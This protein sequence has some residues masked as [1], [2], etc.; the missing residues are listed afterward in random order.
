M[1]LFLLSIL[2]LSFTISANAFTF[3]F[4]SAPTQCANTTAVWTGGQAPFTL[5]LVPVGHLS[6]ETRTIIQKDVPSGNSVSFVLNFPAQSQFVAIL[7]DATG[8]GAGGTSSII[9]VGSSSDSSC[10]STTPSQAKF[11][12]FLPQD[13]GQCDS[14]DISWGSQAQDPVDILGVIPAG[15][16]FEIANVTDSSTSLQWTADV[17]SGTQ[18]MFVAGD[19]DG[20]GTGGSSDV[21]KVSNG[22]SDSCIN[23]NSPSSTSGAAAGGV[24]STAQG[25]PAGGTT[26]RGTLVVTTDNVGSTVTVGGTVTTDGSGSTTTIIGSTGPITTT[27][28]AGSTVTIAGPGGPITTTDNAGSTVTIGPTS[29]IT[30]DNSGSTITLGGGGSTGVN[31]PGSQSSGFTGSG[32]GTVTGS[33]KNGLDNRNNRLGLILGLVLGLLALGLVVAGIILYRRRRQERMYRNLETGANGA[34]RPHPWVSALT[35][36]AHIRGG[37]GS[38]VD[39]LPSMYQT[40]PFIMPST[41]DDSFSV[42]QPRQPPPVQQQRP[43]LA[44]RASSSRSMYSLIGDGLFTRDV[45]GG[46]LAGIHGPDRKESV[47]PHG[48][49]PSRTPSGRAVTQ[50]TVLIPSTIEVPT[51]VTRDSE[52]FSPEPEGMSPNPFNDDVVEIPPTYASVRRASRSG[53]RETW[54]PVRAQLRRSNA[55]RHSRRS[56]LSNSGTGS[57][58]TS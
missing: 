3:S 38:S 55:S 2:L 28:N 9:T 29:P 52:D 26:G 41:E 30:T 43:N 35:R 23:N 13:I 37:A 49:P 27:D 20:L 12:L 50:R 46:A 14:I 58:E 6:P 4:T 34:A 7:N 42:A 40:E 57:Q 5:L 36:G 24:S 54:Q 31:N 47:G 53:D 56:I 21:M 15:Q 16:S 19:K 32:G 11:F 48:R 45:F 1:T 17:R 25:Q 22:N 39:T 10:L 33:S 51:R 44:V 8:V 18:I